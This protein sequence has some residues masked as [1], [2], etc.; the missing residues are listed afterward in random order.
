MVIGDIMI[1]F[2]EL[3]IGD[4]GSDIRYSTVSTGSNYDPKL[5]NVDSDSIGSL[6]VNFMIGIL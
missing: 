6:N 4:R 3:L 2:K 5:I 1:W